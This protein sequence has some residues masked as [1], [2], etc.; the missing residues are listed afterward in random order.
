MILGWSLDRLHISL[1]PQRS[2]TLYRYVPKC[3][4]RLYINMYINVHY[5]WG[6]IRVFAIHQIMLSIHMLL[7]NRRTPQPKANPTQTK[8]RS[9]WQLGHF[10]PQQIPFSWVRIGLYRKQTTRNLTK[11]KLSTNTLLAPATRLARPETPVLEENKT[12]SGSSAVEKPPLSK[13]YIGQ[14]TSHPC[15]LS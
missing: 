2:K 10:F 14:N 5:I 6:R 1:K 9:K 4:E 8:S 13:I 3:K 15:P 7:R 11:T 12:M